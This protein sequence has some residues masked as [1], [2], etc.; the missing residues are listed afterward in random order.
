MP[1]IRGSGVR[2]KACAMLLRSTYMSMSGFEKQPNNE[3]DEDEFFS[4]L[5]QEPYPED[6]SEEDMVF[7]NDL[8]ALFSPE[9]EELPPYYVQTLLTMDDQRFEP[10]GPGFEH[11]TSARVFRRLKLKRRLF[12]RQGTLANAFHDGL[13]D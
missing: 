1:S 5:R 12:Y 3:E 2:E 9:D 13:G 7:T 11:K 4:L 6:F 10:T 8:H